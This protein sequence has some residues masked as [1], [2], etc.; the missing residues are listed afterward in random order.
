[1]NSNQNM[2][3][4]SELQESVDTLKNLRQMF[5]SKDKRDYDFC[6][7]II[8][9]NSKNIIDHVDNIAQVEGSIERPMWG[10]SFNNFVSWA[11][12]ENYKE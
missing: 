10:E 2:E 11:D 8:R 7:E 9:N 4:S 12:L 6:M 3:L 5:Y 1:M